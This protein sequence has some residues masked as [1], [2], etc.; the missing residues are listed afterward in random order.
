MTE[1]GAKIRIFY[2]KSMW[3]GKKNLSTD[4]KSEKIHSGGNSI[5]GYLRLPMGLSLVKTA[6][7]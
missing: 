5:P 2:Y 3:E 1:Y 6:T 7:S 4:K